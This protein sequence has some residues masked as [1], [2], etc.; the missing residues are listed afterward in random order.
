MSQ[1]V[2]KK[3][4]NIK[5]KKRIFRDYQPFLGII[6]FWIL[7][8][9]LCIASYWAIEQVKRTYSYPLSTLLLTGERRFTTKKDIQQAILSTGIAHS[10]MEEDV[11]LL[12]QAIKRFPWVKQVYVRKH[13]PDKLDIH[14][15][16]YVPIA[17]WNDLHLLD[18]EGKI[19]SVPHDRMT[20]ERLVLLYGPE[21]SEQDTLASYLTMDQL[22]SAHQFHLKMAEMS[23]RRSW[24]LILDNEIRLEIGKVHMMSRLKRF[25]ELYPFFENHPDQ[26]IDYIDLRYKNG[27]AVHWSPIFVETQPVQ[28][29]SKKSPP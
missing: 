4:R 15:T 10:F 27:A 11:H 17:V 25:I 8:V 3:A 18:H 2:L 9:V 29:Q 23:A 1:A 24:Q 28:M 26:R 6:F 20:H 14:V 7:L 16:D 21:G 22:L 13:W 19:F 5:K 12:Q